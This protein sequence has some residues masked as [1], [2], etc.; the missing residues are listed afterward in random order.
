MGKSLA[1]SSF[2]FP[3]W[4]KYVHLPR[5]SFVTRK[6]NALLGCPYFRTNNNNKLR[7][8]WFESRDTLNR[9][10]ATRYSQKV[11]LNAYTHH[12]FRCELEWFFFIFYFLFLAL[13]LVRRVR[14]IKLYQE[15]LWE[16]DRTM[17][18]ALE[19]TVEQW[20]MPWSDQGLFS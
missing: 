3:R 13:F 7:A 11:L 1:G 5:V 4:P 20:K 17:R 2:F 16:W 10:F 15:T 18:N 14:G 12:L 19:Y 9:A 8:V 6:I